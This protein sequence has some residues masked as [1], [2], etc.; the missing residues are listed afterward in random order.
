MQSSRLGF[1]SPPS[2]LKTAFTWVACGFPP[3]ASCVYGFRR[4]ARF[5]GGV[6][7]EAS[8]CA[9]FEADLYFCYIN[10]EPFITYQVDI[11]TSDVWAALGVCFV[12]IYTQ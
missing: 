12:H 2:F 6:A 10:R 7:T 1:R 4:T 3:C 5:Q 11:F 9:S 8:S